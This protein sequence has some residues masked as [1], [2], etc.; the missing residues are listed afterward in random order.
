MSFFMQKKA[1]C[2]K[3][4]A[5]Y[6]K[7]CVKNLKNSLNW[8]IFARISNNG[9]VKGFYFAFFAKLF[10]YNPLLMAYLLLKK[11]LLK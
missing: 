2:V 9:L 8:R 7:N 3:R 11:K 1:V 5:L 4:H 10:I 6:A